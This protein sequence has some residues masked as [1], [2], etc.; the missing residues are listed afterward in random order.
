MRFIASIPPKCC[1]M[2]QANSQQCG[3]AICATIA[4]LEPHGNAFLYTYGCLCAFASSWNSSCSLL[5]TIAQ[6]IPQICKYCENMG[7]TN[8][9]RM[10]SIKFIFFT[11][12]NNNSSTQTNAHVC[13][14]IEMCL[15]AAVGVRMCREEESEGGVRKNLKLLH[16][17]YC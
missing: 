12:H 16:T 9:M 15:C 17:F 8:L 10:H 3:A 1:P 6:W 13:G 4:S 2:K 7:R 11:L 5:T 14:W